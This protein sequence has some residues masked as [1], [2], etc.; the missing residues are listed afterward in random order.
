L[1]KNPVLQVLRCLLD[2]GFILKAADKNEVI[3]KKSFKSLTWIILLSGCLGAS[4]AA[5]SLPRP[6]L[7]A[8]WENWGDLRLTEFHQDIN[9][10]QLAFAT[11]KGNSTHEVEF[12]LPN[13]YKKEMFIADLDAFH[14]QGRVL[15]LSI[16]GANDPI[17]LSSQDHVNK[18]VTSVDAILA[19]YDYKIDGIDLDLES[20]SYAFS[21]TWTMIDPAPEQLF[22]IAAVK[23]IMAKH[24]T[25]TGNKLLL[26]M[27]PETVYL[28]GALSNYQVKNSQGGG[29]LPVIEGL[30]EELD[31]LHVQY[32]NAYENVAIDGK[33]Y[34]DNGEGD[35]ITSMTESI[36]K[37]FTLKESKGYWGGLPPEKVAL[38]LPA[39]SCD[40]GTGS[41]W[42]EPA[43]VIQAAKY[44]KGEIAKP[45]D[46]SYTMTDSYPDIA[47]MMMWSGNEDYKNCKGAWSFAKSFSEAF[48][49]TDSTITE[50]PASSTTN[51]FSSYKTKPKPTLVLE[52]SILSLT[53]EYSN[54]PRRVVVVNANGD[55]V[56]SKQLSVGANLSL[57]DLKPGVYFISSEKQQIKFLKK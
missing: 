6:A 25:A 4:W 34:K 36:L 1:G 9:V 33:I 46:W 24:Q 37:G 53:D 29:V 48:G 45:N 40:A 12:N 31:L 27:A 56:K 2:I 23:Q 32:Y 50:G 13:W 15:I 57:S 20:D 17:L 35:F 44:I 52:Q 26:T 39:N 30:R 41:G 42:V 18:F 21:N 22:L 49:V 8:Y 43:K 5:A 54:S 16:G 28:M 47:G 3:M 55:V 7:I 51:V 14:T 10:V 38:G 19:E 11:N